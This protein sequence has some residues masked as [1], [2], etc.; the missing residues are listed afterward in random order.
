MAAKPQAFPGESM[1]LNQTILPEFDHEM[2]NTRTS[3]ERIPDDKLSFKPHVKSMSMGGLATHM[4]T[5]NHWAEAI[6]GL[7]SFD[8]STA[9]PNPELKS[10]AEVLAAFDRNTAIARKALASATDAD[11]MKPWSLTF[12]G[13]NILTLPRIAVVRSF[14]LNHQIHHRAQLGVYLR[15][16]DIPV[17]SIYGPSADEGNM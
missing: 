13:K 15:L 10:Q 11:L 8:A 16:N 1:S 14:L 17:P 12:K 3:L 9:P 2:A 4:A 5:I 7:E 6:F